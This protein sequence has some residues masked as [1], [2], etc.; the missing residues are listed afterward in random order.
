MTNDDFDLTIEM[1]E[2]CH[3]GAPTL[4]SDEATKLQPKVPDWEHVTV[5][6]EPRLRRTFKFDGWLPAVEFVDEIAQ[7]AEA[8]DHHPFIQLEWGK[9]QVSWWTHKIHGLHR[10]D[11]IMAAKTDEIWAKSR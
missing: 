10:N 7:V 9:V 3:R 11:Y 2:A 5:D 4:T 8:N 6:D 1:C